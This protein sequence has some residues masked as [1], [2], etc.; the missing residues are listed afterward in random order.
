MSIFPGQDPKTEAVTFSPGGTESANH[1]DPAQKLG[2]EKLLRERV[3][4][5]LGLNSAARKLAGRMREETGTDFYDW[6][7]HLALGPEDEQAL[8]D[9]GFVPELAQTSNGATVLK[10]PWVTRLRV[11]VEEGMKPQAGVIA[12]R[13]ER[14]AD[15]VSAHGLAGRIEGEP[16]AR[17]RRVVVSEENGARLEAVERNGYRGFMIVPLHI[18]DLKGIIRA[19]DLWRTRP[20]HGVTAGEGFEAANRLLD[21]ILSSVGPDLVCQSFFENERRYWEARN[22][23]G[24][25][26]KCRQDRLGLGWGN[27][28]SHSF[29]CSREH[30]SDFLKILSRLGFEM[31][32]RIVPAGSEP[33]RATQLCLQPNLGI[34]VYANVDLRPEERNVDLLMTEL[35]PISPA[36]EAG[37]W[38]E[39]HGESFLEG[40]MHHMEARFNLEWLREPFSRESFEMGAR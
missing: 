30:V 8:R 16:Y 2:A 24:H 20:R 33:G 7:D 25:F 36:G 5:F 39:L 19:K 26:Q 18:A 40:G 31:N 13:A 6:M 37:R 10:P 1:F 11:V 28:V 34:L 4:S 27:H 21:R 22:L 9:L 35:P 23:A 17:L 12:L 29:H 38:T 15:F 32:G 3:E 14:V